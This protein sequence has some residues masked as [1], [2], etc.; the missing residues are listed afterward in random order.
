MALQLHAE[1]PDMP[2]DDVALR[3]VIGAPEIVQDL[4]TGQQ[5]AGVGCQKVE[6]TLL[7]GGE[8]KLRVAGTYA[9]VQDVDFQVAHPK[10]WSK[11]GGIAIGAPHD[12]RNARR[13][14]FRGEGHGQDV[15]HSLFKSPQSGLEIAAPRK[16]DNG[17]ASASQCGN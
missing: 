13:Q 11:Y 12:R 7:D 2:V 5:P 3:H 8:V 15:V 16:S 9:T 10:Q 6:Q 4:V 14:L 1:V 17:E